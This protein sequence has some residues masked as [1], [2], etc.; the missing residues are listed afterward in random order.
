[1]ATDTQTRLT[2]REY[3]E[4]PESDDRY[5]LIDGELVMAPTPI[6]E[7]QIF[8]FYL[9]KA[10]E[11][12]ITKHRLGRIIISPQDVILS[13]DV[14]LQPDMMFIS[15]ERLSIIKWGRYVEGAPDLVVEV[16]SPSTARHDRAV[17]RDH[18]AKHGVREYWIADIVERM[19]EVN[20]AS[21]GGFMTVGVFGEG[22]VVKSMLLPELEID[23]SGV[24]ENA[25]I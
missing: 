14:V 21:A 10:V 13:D 18:Y 5:E 1:M 17:K 23:V 24:F 22:D 25:R 19:I 20:A 4:L 6:P 3:F 7:H 11:E 16:L 8:L 15:N 2:I 9:A 12:F